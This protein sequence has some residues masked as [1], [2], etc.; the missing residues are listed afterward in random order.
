MGI[1]R[2]PHSATHT[3]PPHTG[4]SHAKTYQ[5]HI[6]P[7]TLDPLL[8]STPCLTTT[9]SAKGRQSTNTRS[10]PRYDCSESLYC[11]D[12]HSSSTPPAPT[13]SL[14]CASPAKTP[15]SI[16]HPNLPTPLHLPARLD[17]HHHRLRPD[18][19]EDTSLTLT[20]QSHQYNHHHLL[21]H[22]LPP[23]T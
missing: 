3:P 18:H 16:H 4:T 14:Y 17:H 9:C 2:V 13:L 20:S 21:L 11:A 10:C 5:P 1:H 22:I 7:A 23:S 12:L 15:P 8:L 19:F 6:C